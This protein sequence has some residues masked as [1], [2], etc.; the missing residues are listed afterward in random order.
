MLNFGLS[1]TDSQ[2]VF[3]LCF[4]ILSGFN[5]FFIS[6]HFL[7]FDYILPEMCLLTWSGIPRSLSFITVC[8]TNCFLLNFESLITDICR[9]CTWV[10]SNFMPHFVILKVL[11]FMTRLSLL[12]VISGIPE[13]IWLWTFLLS[14]PLWNLLC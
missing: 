4:Q 1:F 11:P 6:C 3:S 8:L 14:L 13:R 10:V 12:W 7:G 9:S 2:K 5:N